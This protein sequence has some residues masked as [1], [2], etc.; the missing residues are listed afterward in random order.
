MKQVCDGWLYTNYSGSRSKSKEPFLT[1]NVRL[2]SLS[3]N[4]AI[5]SGVKKSARPVSHVSHQVY[6]NNYKKLRQPGKKSNH[7]N[8]SAWNSARL[9]NYYN[10][11][12]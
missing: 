5:V 2:Q 11:L 6:G 3:S 4:I 10:R 12:G 1:L 9:T 8:V 7:P